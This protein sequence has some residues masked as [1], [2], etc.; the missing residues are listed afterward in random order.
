MRYASLAMICLL[1]CVSDVLIFPSASLYFCTCTFASTQLGWSLIF[2]APLLLVFDFPCTSIV[3]PWFFL[4][5][6]CKSLYL[7]PSSDKPFPRAAVT[8]W[9]ALIAWEIRLDPPRIRCTRR[10][11]YYMCLIRPTH[12]YIRRYYLSPRRRIFVADIVCEE[13]FCDMK[14]CLIDHRNCICLYILAEKGYILVAR[15]Y[16][17]GGQ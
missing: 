7:S 15:L 10:P 11:P 16:I 4:H 8:K 5:L 2:P 3:G 1:S 17:S 9:A 13:N 6:Y 14:K 12:Q